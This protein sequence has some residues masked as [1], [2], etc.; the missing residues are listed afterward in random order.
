MRGDDK[1]GKARGGDP[2]VAGPRI[3]LHRLPTSGMNRCLARA[4][5]RILADAKLGGNR[6]E[7]Q[8]SVLGV[9]CT[10]RCHL[11][12]LEKPLFGTQQGRMTHAALRC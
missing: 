8:F 9:V 1:A 5:A 11:P 7:R 4:D 12:Y 6:R 10:T 3:P 2:V